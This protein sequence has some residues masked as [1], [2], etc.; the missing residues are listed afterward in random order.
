M[1]EKVRI[2]GRKPGRELPVAGAHLCDAE[3]R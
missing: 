2:Q 3:R 1:I